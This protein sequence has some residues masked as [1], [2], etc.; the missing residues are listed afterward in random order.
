MKDNILQS[1]ECI[2]DD[3]V[4]RDIHI[5]Q[6]FISQKQFHELQQ[7][8]EKQEPV[9]M[10]CGLS[11]ISF[12]KM[13]ER[14]LSVCRCLSAI[15]WINITGNATRWE[16][17]QQNNY[18]LSTGYLMTRWWERKW[19]EETCLY[20]KLFIQ[21]DRY[22]L[23]SSSVVRHDLWDESETFSHGVFEVAIWSAHCDKEKCL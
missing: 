8:H 5:D 14:L 12:L 1:L 11:D 19:G 6:L 15:Q 9:S 7:P 4:E 3:L 16:G 10:C 23:L 17:R 2:S 20:I 21:R 13:F 18:V 22:I